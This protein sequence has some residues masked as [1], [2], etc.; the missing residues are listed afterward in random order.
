MRRNNRT[1]KIENR[2]ACLEHGSRLRKVEPTVKAEEKE[3][4]YYK[5]RCG[6]LEQENEFLKS[7]SV[8]PQRTIALLQSPETTVVVKKIVPQPLPAHVP[9]PTA[10]PCVSTPAN[11][12]PPTANRQP[13]TANR[14][15]P[16]ANPRGANRTTTA[17]PPHHHRTVHV[18]CLVIVETCD[19]ILF[20]RI[21]WISE[22]CFAILQCILITRHSDATFL[23]AKRQTGAPQEFCLEHGS[24]LRWV[25]PDC[26]R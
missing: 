12:Q 1:T 6:E 19:L 9:L 8:A 15:P 23:S 21:L 24:R 18:S 26:E 13:P 20:K 10:V 4:T 16:T 3:D 14:Q 5:R 2:G 17:T 25:E 11:R 7:Q 22:F